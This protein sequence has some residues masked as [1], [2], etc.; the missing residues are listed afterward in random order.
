MFDYY[1]ISFTTLFNEGGKVCSNEDHGTY[2]DGLLNYDEF[3]IFAMGNCMPL[4]KEITFVST[5]CEIPLD[6]RALVSHV[7]TIDSEGLYKGYEGST[8]SGGVIIYFARINLVD[9]LEGE[10]AER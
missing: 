6:F 5:V 2:K 7:F 4:F 1:I 8:N 10:A 9:I 3:S